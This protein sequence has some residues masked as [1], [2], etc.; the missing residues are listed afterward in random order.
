MTHKVLLVCLPFFLLFYACKS[1]GGKENGPSTVDPD[2]VGIPV[3][4]MELTRSSGNDK[5]S[6]IGF[7]EAKTTAS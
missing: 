1:G 4:V 6:F 2:S 5:L 3:T 7:T